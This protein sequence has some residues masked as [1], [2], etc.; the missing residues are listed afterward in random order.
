MDTWLWLRN[1]ES[2]H[3]NN[4][5]NTNNSGFNYAFRVRLKESQNRKIF[6]IVFRSQ[7]NRGTSI[8]SFP[9]LTIVSANPK[10]QNPKK[11]GKADFTH[12]ILLIISAYTAHPV[13]SFKS[14]FLPVRG[15]SIFS[16]SREYCPAL[17][18]V[19]FK[20]ELNKEEGS[21]F[22]CNLTVGFPGGKARDK[23][24]S[25]AAMDKLDKRKTMVTS[26]SSL[27]LDDSFE[28]SVETK[29]KNSLCRLFACLLLDFLHTSS[30]YSV[31]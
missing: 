6:K 21:G 5:N 31:Y 13:D 23:R 12:I 15:F 7:L 19:V 2:H 29:V 3:L 22:L 4:N 28:S 24:F 27:S 26:S 1:R 8:I 25:M 18:R 20:P 11:Q 10:I 30:N 16:R 9:S 17:Y 14:T